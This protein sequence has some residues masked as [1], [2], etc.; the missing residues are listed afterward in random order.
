[1]QKYRC[2]VCDYEYDPAIG[3]PENDVATGTAFEDIPDEWFCPICG[4]DKTMFE[5]V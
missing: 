3:D 2:I 1:M 5:A 4:A